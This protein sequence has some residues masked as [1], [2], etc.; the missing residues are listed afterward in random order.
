MFWVGTKFHLR[1]A[2]KW[3]QRNIEPD[4]EVLAKTAPTP[5]R[6]VTKKYGG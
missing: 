5:P 3:L 4:S 6:T 1:S 2:R